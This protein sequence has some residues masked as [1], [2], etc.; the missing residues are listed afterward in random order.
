MHLLAIAAVALFGALLAYASWE[1]VG[2]SV[3]PTIELDGPIT[4]K[5][6]D[7]RIVYRDNLYYPYSKGL[8]LYTVAL[9]TLLLML[10][11]ERIYRVWRWPA[12]IGVVSAILIVAQFDERGFDFLLDTKEDVSNILGVV[13][14]ALTLLIALVAT[15]VHKLR[16]RNTK[17]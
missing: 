4:Q 11:P 13:F 8:L 5:A 10:F 3:C 12:A 14:L 17:T 16:T 6:L 9:S 7:C 1:V 2:K 15:I